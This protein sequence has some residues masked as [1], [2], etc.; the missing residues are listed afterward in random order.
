LKAVVLQSNYFPWR[1]YFDLI[2]KCETFIF[3]DEVKYTKND[4]RNRNQV[5]SEK[6]SHWITIQ[7][8]GESVKKRIDEVTLD[9]TSTW[10]KGHID[11]LKFCYCRSPLYK[12]QLLPLIEHCLLEFKTNNLAELNQYIIKLISREAGFQTKFRNSVEFQSE[13]NKA[14]KLLSLLKDVGVT[15]YL[16]GAAAKDYLTGMEGNFADIGVKL[17][18]FSYPSYKAYGNQRAFFTPY[19]SILDYMAY[20]DLKDLSL[21]LQEATVNL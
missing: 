20:E 14:H 11:L 10:R 8:S 13:G 1:G 18:Y 7:V 4:W 19:L 9:F 2:R 15:E 21:H 17:D 12:K 5:C 16:S 6:G 3:Y